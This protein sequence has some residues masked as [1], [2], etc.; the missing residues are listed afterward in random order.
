MWLPALA[1]L[2]AVAFL[3][4]SFGRFRTGPRLPNL[5][6]FLF[7]FWTALVFLPVPMS[8]TFKRSSGWLAVI[9]AALFLLGDATLRI[10]R[11]LSRL[12]VF[13]RNG[14]ARLPAYLREICRAM[15]RMAAD[16]TGALI[17]IE[18]KRSLGEYTE[19]AMRF[20]SEVK[21]DLIV[22]LFAASSPLHDGA[23]VVN[24]GRIKAAR[25]ILP[26]TTRSTVPMGFGTRHRSAIG[27]TERT[28]AVALVVSEEQGTM[29]I[30]YKG[31]LAGVLSL[32]RLSLL[33][34][35]ALKGKEIGTASE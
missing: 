33:I 31:T 7:S 26:L 6:L 8:D 28:D 21:S 13:K 19:A 17:V 1:F 2:T 16:R 34:Q 11:R 3:L 18:G 4:R 32:E 15:E 10:F 5:L 22:S 20:D 29:S 30:A 24:K 14:L 12:A 27:I 35:T 23:L 9:L 25:V